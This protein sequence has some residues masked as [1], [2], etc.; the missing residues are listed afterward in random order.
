MKK[1]IGVILVITLLGVGGWKCQEDWE[2]D[3]HSKS[4]QMTC[5]P[6]INTLGLPFSGCEFKCSQI[7]HYPWVDLWKTPIFVND[8]ITWEH[9]VQGCIKRGWDVD[10]VLRGM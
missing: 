6:S 3:A 8:P 1:W 4:P 5:I 10:E 9:I 7:K 2:K